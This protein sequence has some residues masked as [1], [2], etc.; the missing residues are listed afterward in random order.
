MRITK[1]SKQRIIERDNG[2]SSVAEAKKVAKLAF[3]SGKR[4][5]DFQKCPKFFNY[6][7][8]KAAQTYEC[9]V[10]VYRGNIYIWRGRKHTLVTAHP[11]PDRFHEELKEL[12]K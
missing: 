10:R 12:E 6:L 3:R 4:V 1:H 11:I 9:S 5:G 8:N 2:V 7:Q